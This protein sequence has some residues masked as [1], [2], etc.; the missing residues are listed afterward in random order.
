MNIHRILRIPS[1]LSALGLL[2]LLAG[3]VVPAG[4]LSGCAGFTPSAP[5]ARADVSASGR[6]LLPEERLK[7]AA[8]DSARVPEK[9]DALLLVHPFASN[10][11]PGTARTLAQIF[12]RIRS[13]GPDLPP[14]AAGSPDGTPY[15]G[16]Q[17]T[18]KVSP[19]FRLVR[20]YGVPAVDSAEGVYRVRWDSLALGEWKAVVAEVEGYLPPSAGKERLI[21]ATLR[22]TRLADGGV[23]ETIEGTGME[24]HNGSPARLNPWTAR[25]SLYA[26]NAEALR[27]ADRLAAARRPEQGLALLDLQLLSIQSLKDLDPQGIA[28]EEQS[29]VDAR[30][31]LAARVPGAPPAPASLSADASKEA[32]AARATAVREQSAKAPAGVWS[33]LA[34][35]IA[36]RGR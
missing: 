1:T 20:L 23:F 15:L 35:L 27:E 28:R 9:A 11:L 19:G 6:G 24:W 13:T 8:Q 34:Q 17:M 12:V 18:I 36:V 21:G 25:N 10:Q 29:L 7:H 32:Q 14:A 31:A 22:T 16:A 5:S 3:L 4:T 2:P 33:T 30:S 26:A